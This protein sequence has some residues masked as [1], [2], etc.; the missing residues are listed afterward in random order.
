[1]REHVFFGKGTVYCFLGELWSAYGSYF[2][3]VASLN[4]V[5]SSVRY[6]CLDANNGIN[7]SR[8]HMSMLYKVF[9]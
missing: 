6:V 9:I 7:I 5:T 8:S 4:C 2:P 3:S 1:M